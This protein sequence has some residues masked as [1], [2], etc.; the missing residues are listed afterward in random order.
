MN[1]KRIKLRKDEDFITLGVMLKMA[2]LISTGGQAKFFLMDND[3]FINNEIDV[4]RGRK[5]YRGDI[6]AVGNELFLIE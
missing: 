3:V 4:R 2:G 1:P 6:I 5:L